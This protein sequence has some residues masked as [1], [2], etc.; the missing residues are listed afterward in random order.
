MTTRWI[1]LATV[2]F[3]A[4]FA[5]AVLANGS[6]VRVP[7]VA[8]IFV[9]GWGVLVLL[10][11]LGILVWNRADRARLRELALT[12]RARRLER[13]RRCNYDL[14]GTRA[15][16]LCPECGLEFQ[17]FSSTPG[18]RA[19]PRESPADLPPNTNGG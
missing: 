17:K 8:A 7:H 5:S 4:P 2:L 11:I 12:L 19:A 3:L 9:V 14:S 13:C 1:V 10:G 15:D 16:G 18:T 6:F